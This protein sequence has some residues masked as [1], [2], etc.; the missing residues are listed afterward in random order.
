MAEGTDAGIPVKT[1]DST[2]QNQRVE[3]GKP[4]RSQAGDGVVLDVGNHTSPFFRNS[5][6]LTTPDMPT[7]TGSDG[8]ASPFDVPESAKTVDLGEREPAAVV[9]H[10]NDFE[11]IAPTP[12]EP[13]GQF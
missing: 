6:A 1:I 13:L 5:N 3:S 4:Q 10:T 12:L 2:G 11:S 7:T 8:G 9:G